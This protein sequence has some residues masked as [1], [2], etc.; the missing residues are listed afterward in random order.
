MKDFLHS[1]LSSDGKISSKRL[2]TFGS[3][4]AI[5]I[6][7]FC[8]M[9]LGM[10]VEPTM[11]ETMQWIVLGGLGFTASEKFIKSKTPDNE[12]QA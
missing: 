12:Q 2:V 8:N 6:G 9:I 7:F 5:F 3:F 11:L 1:M 4:L 10:K